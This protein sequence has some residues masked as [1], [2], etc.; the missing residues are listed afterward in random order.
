M[1]NKR[2][3]LVLAICFILVLSLKAEAYINP[4]SGSDFFQMFASGFLAIAGGFKHL[5]NKIKS[6]LKIKGN[7]N[8]DNDYE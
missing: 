8:V 5:V 4:G 3:I 6:I 2:Q 7:E 1:R